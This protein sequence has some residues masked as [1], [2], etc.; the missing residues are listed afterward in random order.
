MIKARKYQAK[1]CCKECKGAC[2]KNLPGACLPEDIE[3]IF[4]AETLHDSVIKA[5][6]TKK[7]S[8]DWWEGSSNV[9]Y[10]R[11][12]TKGKY[13]KFDPSWG[14]ECVFLGKGGCKLSFIDRPHN[15]KILQP[16]PE[17]RCK[18]PFKES[19]KLVYACEWKDLDFEVFRKRN[20]KALRK[21]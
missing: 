15:C 11:P 6:S 12:S 3:R 4:P 5:L 18:L 21:E 10:I 1:E 13:R 19:A 20:N 8:I 7:F 9:Y 14:G 16:L 17:G 2:C